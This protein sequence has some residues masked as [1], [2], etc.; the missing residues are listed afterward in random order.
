ML[1]NSQMKT[2]VRSKCFVNI[3]QG[4]GGANR[5]K[6]RISNTCDRGCRFNNQLQNVIY[7]EQQLLRGNTARFKH[8]GVKIPECYTLRT[9]TFREQIQLKIETLIL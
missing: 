4:W 9:G 1:E 8:S 7:S 2:C 5:A 3:A 6:K